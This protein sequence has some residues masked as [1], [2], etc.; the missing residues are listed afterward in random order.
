ME[1][2]NKHIEELLPRYCEGGLNTE[3]AQ[4]VR[5]WMER[6]EE[7]RRVVKQIHM[8][9]LAADTKIVLEKINTE[10][11]LTK[12]SQKINTDKTKRMNFSFW[13]QRI[14]AILFVPL[15]I[16]YGFQFVKGSAEPISMIEVKTNPGMTT[17]VILP[18][19]S[20]AYLNSETTL[21]YPSRFSGNEREVE[22]NGEAFF[23]VEKDPQKKFI[24][25]TPHQSRIEVL[26]THFNIDAYKKDHFVS[27]TLIEGKVSFCYAKEEAS[28]NIVLSPG[29]KLVYD[30]ITSETRIIKTNGES[31]ISWKEGKII[32]AKTPMKEALRMLEK[33]YNVEFIIKN[34]E[35]L[36]DP[37]S[38][39]FTHQRLERILEYF[40]VSSNINWSYLESGDIDKEKSKIVIY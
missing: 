19:G 36:E 29:Q 4:E 9:Y 24:V 40:K 6:S 22:I 39:T 26:G 25:M 32:F 12:V 38:G 8:L 13:V 1:A 2:D 20:T 30:M 11:T 33:R 21:T 7:N 5:E 27:T 35:L 16:T 10:K 28:K 23:M 15:L 18:D 34:E 31:E 14:A 37:F 17:S 3:E